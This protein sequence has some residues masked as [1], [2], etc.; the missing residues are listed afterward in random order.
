MTPKRLDQLKRHVRVHGN[1]PRGMVE[2]LI[3]ELESC[4]ATLDIL[5]DPTALESLRRSEEDIK[6]GRVRDAREVFAELDA[7]LDSESAN[8][9]SSP[10]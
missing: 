7:E 8:G 10:R 1:L 9:V 6:A 2:E 4:W 5:S 3:A